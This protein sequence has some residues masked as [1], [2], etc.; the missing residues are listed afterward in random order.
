L[1]ENRASIVKLATKKVVA[2]D[3]GSMKRVALL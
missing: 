3:K 1:N 2:I